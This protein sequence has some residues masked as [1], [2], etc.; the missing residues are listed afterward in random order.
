[1]EREEKKEKKNS[2]LKIYPT[3]LLLQHGT[4]VIGNPFKHELCRTGLNNFEWTECGAV[5]VV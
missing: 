5:L 1:M 2:G 4:F 3:S